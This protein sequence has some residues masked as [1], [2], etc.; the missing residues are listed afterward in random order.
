MLSVIYVQSRLINYLSEFSCMFP[1]SETLYFTAR[2]WISFLLLFAL[3]HWLP[4]ENVP[5]L[6]TKIKQGDVNPAKF[7]THVK[8]GIEANYRINPLTEN[9]GSEFLY[10]TCKMKGKI[11]NCF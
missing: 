9:D 7:D 6:P 10:L 8:G 5:L 4:T 11:S 1:C 3:C 2:S